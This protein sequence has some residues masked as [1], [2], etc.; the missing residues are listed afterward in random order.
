MY[1]YNVQNNRKK[2]RKK[3]QKFMGAPDAAN[4]NEF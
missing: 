2:L 1:K 4:M 3:L